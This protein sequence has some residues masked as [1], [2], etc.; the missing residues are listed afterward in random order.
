MAVLV[1]FVWGAFSASLDRAIDAAAKAGDPAPALAAI[2]KRS[3][4]AQPTAYNHAIRRLWDAYER[5][6]AARL[7]CELGH[8]HDSSKI[9]Q[10][11]IQQVMSTEPAIA[12]EAFS[13][14]FLSAHYQP[15]VA[16][17]CGKV[18]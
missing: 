15:E 17:T 7:V 11:W 10:Y 4:D 3:P 9:T 1:F 6:I 18:G 13:E 8:H 16:A 5:Q 12:R 14:D 2:A